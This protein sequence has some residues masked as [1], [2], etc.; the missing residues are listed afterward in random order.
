M[1]TRS[2][3]IKELTPFERVC[4]LLDSS[5][6]S[7]VALQA[8]L[9][10]RNAVA[11]QN[12]GPGEKE[13][14][15]YLEAYLLQQGF[16]PVVK[17]VAMDGEVLRPN[18]VVRVQG[19]DNSR[20]LWFM[21]HMD[22]VPPGDINL[23][24]SDPFTLRLEGEKIV[25]RGVEDNHQGMVASIFALNALLKSGITPACDIGLLFLADEETGSNY[26]I[27]YLLEKHREIFGPNDVFIVPDAGESDGSLVEVAEKSILW[28]KIRTVGKQVHAS[29]PNLGKNAFV[30][31][32]HLVVKLRGLYERFDKRDLLF[33]PPSSTF[34]PTKK[35][36]NVGNINTIP[37]ED[38]FYV[39]ARI[40][41]GIS[42]EEVL[43]VIR[44]MADEIARQFRVVVNVDIVNRED[45]APPTPPD[46]K[47]V[48]DMISAIKKV[49]SLDAKPRGIGGGTVAS[50]LRKAGFHAVVWSKVD[51]TAHQPNEYVWISN[52]IGDA[53]VFAYLMM[54]NPKQ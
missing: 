30:A 25:G 44:E 26:G 5:K 50:H 17:Y 2:K 38:V 54:G 3:R 28:L 53:K 34:E 12:G 42:L 35:D 52:M 49:Y 19:T 9:V 51:E 8:E 27:K 32:S 14:A 33:Q 39:D 43:A 24:K 37:G 36:P 21:T 46:A 16:P 23:W 13:K 11:P 31:G 7:M 10:K 47:I 40:L 4:Q 6:D 15:D 18:L 22:V 1:G 29:T 45:A 48:Q 41:P 20:C